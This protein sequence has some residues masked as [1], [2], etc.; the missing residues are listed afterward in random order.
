[1]AGWREANLPKATVTGVQAVRREPSGCDA[2]SQQRRGLPCPS[3]YLFLTN[4]VTTKT[5]RY[6]SL[7]EVGGEADAVAGAIPAEAVRLGGAGAAW[8]RCR[9]RHTGA[10]ERRQG[11]PSLF[12]GHPR[13]TPIVSSFCL[14]SNLVS[15]PHFRSWPWGS[16]GV[17]E[18]PARRAGEV[19]TSISL[20]PTPTL[21]A[22]PVVCFIFTISSYYPK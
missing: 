5:G 19:F 18:F 20:S 16:E 1:M 3:H 8:G 17:F 11:P 22:S 14:S 15:E 9:A 6:A 7:A 10:G 12:S 13:V 21:K 2:S 4:L